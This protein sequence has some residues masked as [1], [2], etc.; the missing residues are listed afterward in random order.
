[1]IEAFAGRRIALADIYETMNA[2]GGAQALDANGLTV[3]PRFLGSRADHSANGTIRG[4]DASN[5]QPSR[6]SYAR[7]PMAS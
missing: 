3:D 7:L 5:L 2:T 6:S 1:M 4:I